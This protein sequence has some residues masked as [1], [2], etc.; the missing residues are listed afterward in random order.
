MGEM[1]LGSQR[2]GFIPGVISVAAE[3]LP[4][5]AGD[6]DE[7]GWARERHPSGCA[8]LT[9]Q[10]RGHSTKARGLETHSYMMYLRPLSL[11]GR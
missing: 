11:Q 1:P 7:L 6:A 9:S 2:W 10:A 5:E 8:M 4:G 3:S